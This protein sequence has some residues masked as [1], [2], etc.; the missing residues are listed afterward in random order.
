MLLSKKLGAALG[1]ASLLMALAVPATSYA[2]AAPVKKVAKPTT[3]FEVGGRVGYGLRFTN[4]GAKGTSH[5]PT[6]NSSPANQDI[7][8]DSLLDMGHVFP[9]TGA[10]LAGSTTSNGITFG[11]TL[12]FGQY[13]NHSLST[14]NPNLSGRT[15]ADNKLYG[16][17]PNS[18]DDLFVGVS[19]ADVYMTTNGFTVLAGYGDTMS[20]LG[21]RAS[22]SPVSTAALQNF[23]TVMFTTKTTGAKITPRN[24]TPMEQFAVGFGQ[25]VSNR[26]GVRYEIDGFTVGLDYVTQNQYRPAVSVA[27]QSLGLGGSYSGS[28]QGFN[29]VVRAG[30]ANGI[31]LGSKEAFSTFYDAGNDENQ[32]MFTRQG[33]ELDLS[34][35]L[36]MNGFNVSAGLSNWNPNNDKKV[37]ATDTKLHKATGYELQAGYTFDMGLGGDSNFNVG[38]YNATDA[39]QPSLNALQVGGGNNIKHEDSKS[40]ATAFTVGFTQQFSSKAQ[41]SIKFVSIPEGEFTY[42]TAADADSANLVKVETGSMSGAVFSMEYTF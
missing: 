41:A 17:E 30:W 28:A 20:G 24:Q 36:E 3:T 34:V 14:E 35:A 5:K 18:W 32:Y 21:G 19:T 7:S 4:N 42:N 8:P 29:Y 39:N 2:A 10:Y 38:Y 27:G 26:L 23:A 16:V 33:T 11:A 13:A 37:N 6:T 40:K 22:L 9:G 25:D 1:C 31:V 15:I 12:V